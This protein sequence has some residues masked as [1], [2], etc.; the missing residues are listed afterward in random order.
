MLNR[1]VGYDFYPLSYHISSFSGVISL[2]FS[3]IAEN[4]LFQILSLLFGNIRY[5]FLAVFSFEAFI[6]CLASEI[7]FLTYNL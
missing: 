2:V 5:S 1:R 3:Q 7:S 6:N 4:P